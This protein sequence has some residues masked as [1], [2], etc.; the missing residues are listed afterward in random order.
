M[1]LRHASGDTPVVV[2][3]GATQGFAA[4]IT[5]WVRDRSLFVVTTPRVWGLHGDSLEPLLQEAC[6]WRYLEV[7]DGE[8][9]KSIAVAERL[10]DRMLEEGGKRDSR[11]IAFGG[12]T[13]GDVAGFAA[14]C[15][16]RG[17]SILQL[18]TT[19]LAQ[20]DA[21]IG[22][23][24][25]INLAAAKN[26]V[27]VF[28]QPW[29]VVAD[30][31]YL[32]TLP[33]EE[34]RA[35]LLEVVKAGVILD[36]ELFDRVA[37]D[38]DALLEGDPEALPPIVAA[39]AAAKIGVVE[40]DPEEKDRRRLLNFG[41]TLGHALEAMAGYSSLRHGEAVGYGMLFALRLA[42]RRGLRLDDA[43][44][45]RRLI[46]RFR[47]PSLP[48]MDPEELLHVMARDKKARE[49]GLFWVLPTAVGKARITAEVEEK[50]VLS[51]LAGFL[52]EPGSDF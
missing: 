13:V 21:A 33:P 14:G 37:S 7:P 40:Q 28:Q 2:G 25:G 12:G 1:S 31:E 3:N 15:F 36:A 11:V 49:A 45:I 20:V 32:S 35:G 44:R 47:L 43:D 23:K 22:G 5:D 41:H 17:V 19:L 52:D 42:V 10:W 24:T 9:A 16:L 18:P 39:A 34:L 46:L 38:L 6:R 29:A 51:E 48:E 26:S 30:T 8:A 4:E 50:E 27:G